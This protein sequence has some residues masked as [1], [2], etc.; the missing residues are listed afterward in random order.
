MSSKASL[1]ILQIALGVVL[2]AYSVEL[3][4]AQFHSG[5]HGHTFFVFLI[6]GAV[7]A[8]AAATF[9]FAA[10]AG[11][12]VLLAT[13]AFAGALHLLHGEVGHVGIL[14]IYA[15]AVL[16]VMSGKRG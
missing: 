13:F 9:L 12:S 7:E 4:V 8:A 11:G 3:V 5:H 14:L 1:R 15:A 2:C 16:A 10:S 6:L